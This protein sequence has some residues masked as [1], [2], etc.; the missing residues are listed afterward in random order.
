MSKKTKTILGVLICLLGI[1]LVA[2]LRDSVHLNVLWRTVGYFAG[3]IIWVIGFFIVQ[4]AEDG[5]K[6]DKS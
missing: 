3:L 5:D 2:A 4:I 1:I 6:H